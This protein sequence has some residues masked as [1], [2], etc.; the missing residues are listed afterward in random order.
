[1]CIESVA[2]LVLALVVASG[3]AAIRSEAD[4]GQRRRVS[5]SGVRPEDRRP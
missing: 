4:E 5:R 1:M 2:F 3:A